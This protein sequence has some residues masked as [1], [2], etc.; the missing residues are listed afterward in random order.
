MSLIDLWKSNP[1]SFEHYKARQ[2]VAFAGDGTLKDNS[3]CSSELRQYLN[4]VPTERLSAYAQECLESSFPD[5]G[6]VLQ[7][8]VNEL[9]RRL[10]FEVENGRYRGLPGQV[11]FDGIWQVPNG[12]A[13]VVEVKTTDTYNVSL[14]TVAKYRSKL[15]EAGKLEPST[16]ILFAVGRNDTG[17]LEAQ[18]RGSRYAWDMRV[19]GVDSLLKL[20]RVK[21]KSSEDQTIVQIRELLRPFEYTRVDRILDV[22]F[23][24]ATDVITEEASDE[25]GADD[26]APSAGWTQE[27]TPSQTIDEIRLKAAY[28]LS[29]VIGANLVRKRQ[30]LFEDKAKGVRACITVSKRY[31]SALQPYWYA[32]HPKWDD[33]LGEASS[34]VMV[35]ACVDR[36][37]AFAIPVEEMRRILPSLNQTVRPENGSYWHVKFSEAQGDLTLFA[38]KTGERFDLKPFQIELK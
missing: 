23:S 25:H 2:I 5:S 12:P 16:S 33:F 11:G 4:S 35:F 22:V 19:V 27:K 32:Y 3:V 14:D 37:E 29:Q 10:E 28:S 8:V 9:G 18:I 20:V 24:A 34:G 38:S 6:L 13:V 7:D 15:I 30:A 21:E 26:E 17:A 31:P 1:A 36:D